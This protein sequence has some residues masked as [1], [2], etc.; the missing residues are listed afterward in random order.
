MSTSPS[1]LLFMVGM[2]VRCGWHS[3]VATAQRMGT[4]SRSIACNGSSSWWVGG[5]CALSRARPSSWQCCESRSRSLLCIV[6]GG[7]TAVATRNAALA[8]LLCLTRPSLPDLSTIAGRP[9]A[10]ARGADRGCAAPRGR[11][12]GTRTPRLAGT[13]PSGALPWRTRAHTHMHTHHAGRTI[14]VP[15]IPFPF[16]PQLCRITPYHSTTHHAATRPSNCS[17][18]CALGTPA[19]I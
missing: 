13:Q 9:D 17:C 12:A 14:C 10:T 8:G 11:A 1:L 6:A 7:S 2:M 19:T 15:S 16:L 18:S 5:R 3:S 4:P